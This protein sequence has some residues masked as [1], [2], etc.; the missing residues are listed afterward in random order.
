MTF[1]QAMA[2]NNAYVE[3]E[4]QGQFSLESLKAQAQSM[5]EGLKRLRR[6]IEKIEKQKEA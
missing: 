4:A 6:Q 3:P 5:E 2:Q 1:N